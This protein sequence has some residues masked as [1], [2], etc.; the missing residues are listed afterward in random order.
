M[1][2]D[3]IKLVSQTPSQAP[4]PSTFTFKYSAVSQFGIGFGCLAIFTV[5]R[6]V[7][8]TYYKDEFDQKDDT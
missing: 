8:K 3:L 4:K 2:I 5:M 1:K 7:I 6:W